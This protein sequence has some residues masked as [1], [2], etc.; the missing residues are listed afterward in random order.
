M[1]ARHP[2]FEHGAIACSIGSPIVHSFKQEK[3]CLAV[4]E[5]HTG[6]AVA[7]LLSS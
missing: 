4:L 5:K 2:F 1:A 6:G 7:I 3:R